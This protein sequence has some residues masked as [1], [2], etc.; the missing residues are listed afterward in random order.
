M[1][2]TSQTATDFFKDDDQPA[3]PQNSAYYF[4]N[5]AAQYAKLDRFAFT[6]KLFGADPH[7]GT[8]AFNGKTH[9]DFLVALSVLVTQN[10]GTMTVQEL[11]AVLETSTSLE[12]VS[13]KNDFR[14]DEQDF[15]IGLDQNQELIGEL[16]SGQMDADEFTDWTYVYGTSPF[17]ISSVTVISVGPNGLQLSNALVIADPENRENFDF[18]SSGDSAGPF[19]L[20]RADDI[21]PDGGTPFLIDYDDSHAAAL[22]IASFDQND[23]NIAFAATQA[24][25]AALLHKR[26]GGFT[27]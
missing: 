9:A 24:H 16:L 10:G 4:D 15:I 25:K 18:D 13:L 19:N 6:Q 3:E 14:V 27:V 26:V 5:S 12:A 21:A 2:I 11:L 7:F 17:G 8:D 1:R 22:T 20:A 23:F